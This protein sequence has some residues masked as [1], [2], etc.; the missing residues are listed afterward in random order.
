MDKKIQ[1]REISLIEISNK[2]Q[3]IEDNMKKPINRKNWIF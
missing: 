2:L 1:T 3:E